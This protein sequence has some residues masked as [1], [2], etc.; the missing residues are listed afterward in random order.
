M[1][2]VIKYYIFIAK[3][4]L[5]ASLFLYTL[6]NEA[7]AHG[8]TSASAT[9]ELRPNRLVELKVQFDL[10]DL[11]NHKEK[12]YSLSSLASLNDEQFAQL[13]SQ[14]VKLF[15]VRLNVKNKQG[16]MTLHRRYPSKED[17]FMLIKRQFISETL[18]IEAQAIPY[19]FSDRRYYQ[20]VYFDFKLNDSSRIDDVLVEFPDEL[21][22]IY[23][24]YAEPTTR[25][26]HKGEIWSLEK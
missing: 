12:K 7:T 8:L 25:E 15:D 16:L 10:I 20:I 18:D 11:L 26:V 14:I 21:G 6:I 2:T 17:V 3:C 9:I 13:Y 5:L 19:T 4:V 24:T 23:V 1:C 22:D